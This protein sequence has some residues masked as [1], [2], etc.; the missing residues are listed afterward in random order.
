MFRLNV[1]DNRNK[2]D[3]IY[4]NHHTFKFFRK[5]D[6]AYIPLEHKYSIFSN[7][8]VEPTIITVV[9]GYN[10]NNKCVYCTQRKFK[11]DKCDIYKLRYYIDTL[12]KEFPSI[13]NLH[14]IGGEPLLEF[15]TIINLVMHYDKRFKYSIITNGL[16]INR[17]IASFLI[18]NNFEVTISHDGESQLLQRGRDI[19]NPLYPEFKTIQMLSKR[20]TLH[21][22]SVLCGDST[23]TKERWEYF[24]RLPIDI[25]TV[26]VKPVIPYKKEHISL[27]P[28]QHDWKQYLTQLIMDVYE[29]NSRYDWDRGDSN[30]ILDMV[31][32]LAN[33]ETK[34][35]SKRTRCPIFN[36][37]IFTINQG[38]YIQYCHNCSAHIDE[39][40]TIK[41]MRKDRVKECVSCPL[42]LTCTS[43][44]RLLDDDCFKITC[45]RKFHHNLAYFIYFVH[46]TFGYVITSIEGEFKHAVNGKFEI[47]T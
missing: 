46:Q 34:Y 15:D 39:V 37:N 30:L 13:Q 5:I 24:S 40:Q 1:I 9:L 16:H 2:Q 38:G 4:F 22:E 8:K 7:S 14:F 25:N 44:C 6:N 10:C 35:D 11:D 17:E 47:A 19:F 27:V 33:T 21:I 29:I 32:M 41:F 23:T 18:A 31:R 36:K 3:V 43:A 45:T 42:V 12:I 28:G 20:V 26:Y